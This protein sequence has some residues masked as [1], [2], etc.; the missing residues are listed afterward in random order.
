MNI[1]EHLAFHRLRGM[2]TLKALGHD[3]FSMAIVYPSFSDESIEKSVDNNQKSFR[4]H[5]PIMSTR[6]PMAHSAMSTCKSCRAESFQ[7]TIL[8]NNVHTC[9]VGFY[10]DF[11]AIEDV[12][13]GM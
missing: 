12:M 1:L 11:A 3:D 10:V 9:H 6:I 2:F 5:K 4:G 7:A 8:A 13:G